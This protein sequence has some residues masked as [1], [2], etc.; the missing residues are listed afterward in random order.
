MMKKAKNFLKKLGPGFITGASDDDPSGIATYSQTGAIFGLSQ[1]WT[2]LFTFPFMS[3]V[4]VMCGKIGLITGKGL[5]GVLNKYYPKWILYIAVSILFVSNTVNIGADLGA[6]ASSAQLI[7]KIPFIFWLI[8]MTVTTL[9]LEIFVS[10][11]VYVKFLKYLAF[12]L[13]AYIITAFVVKAD[14]QNVFKSTIIP[15]IIPTK[16][17][18][19]NIVAILGTT[20]APYLFFWQADEEVEE[21]VE[22]GKIRSFGAGIPRVTPKDITN[23]RI[24][25]FIGMFFSNIIMFFIILTTAAT[26]NVHGIQI[27]TIGDAASALKPLAGDF[28]FLLFSIGIIGTGFLAV[29]ILAGSASY[30]ISETFGWKAGLY[31]KVTR[32]HGFYGVITL[33]TLV[34]LLINFIGIDPVKSLYYTA[35]LNGIAAPILIFFILHIA[36]NKKILG[37]STNGW[38]SNILG[39]ITAV[40]MTLAAVILIWELVT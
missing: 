26:L 12:C 17:Y 15:T 28:A 27:N 37:K 29:P 32:A 33:A 34:G 21:E 36:N 2:A 23:L 18:F 3:V 22:H 11:K 13:L 9:I 39:I 40:V 16:E 4:Q 8:F 31:R 24:D 14:W 10:Y 30:A 19:M 7:F 35:I 5:A 25:T 1:L 38:L 6:M 20:I